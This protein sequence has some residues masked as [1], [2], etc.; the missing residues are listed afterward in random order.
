M[1][2]QDLTANLFAAFP[3]K[4]FQ[5]TAAAHDCDE[6]A[7]LRSKLQGS[8]WTLLTTQFVDENADV[9]PLLTP[10]AYTAYLP[11]WL[12]RAIEDP[13]SEGAA[14]LMVN[15]TMDCHNAAVFTPEQRKAI[16]AIAEWVCET[17]VF[18]PQDPV[19]KETIQSVR[20]LWG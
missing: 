2:H 6:C 7:A 17:N 5:G 1:N 15:L 10:E 14:M 11:A 13:D 4:L 20:E 16:V 9:L 3:P 19:N 18:G 8:S 12:L